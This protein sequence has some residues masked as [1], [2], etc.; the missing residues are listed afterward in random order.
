M[1]NPG[2]MVVFEGAFRY[3]QIA[4]LVMLTPLRMLL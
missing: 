4:K 2:Q 1:G 3:H